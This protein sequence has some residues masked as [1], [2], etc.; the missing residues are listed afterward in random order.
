M[1]GLSGIITKNKTYSFNAR[2]KLL[3]MTEL[4][5]HRG[6]DQAGYLNFENVFLSH[7][8]LSVMDP[9]NLGR[10]PMSN[11][12]R[13]AII[14]NGEIY[15]F[16]EIRKTLTD[17][18]YTFY[19]NTDTEVGLNA[20][21]EWGDKCFNIFNGDWVISILDKVKKKIIIA[22]DQI[23][24]L[25][26]Y[27]YNDANLFAFSSE[28]KGLEPIANLQYDENFIGLNS[29]TI[30]NFHGTKFKNVS[31]VKPGTYLSI[32]LE[33]KKIDTL[34]WFSPLDNLVSIYPSYKQNQSEIF[35]R[36]YNATKLRLNADIKVGTS[37]SGGLDSSIIFLIMNLIDSNEKI[38]KVDLNPTIVNYDGNLTFNEA[39]QF[40]N[41]HE[42]KYNLFNSKMPFEIN[43]LTNLLSQLE[44]TE[45][46]N[47]QFDLY[48]EQKK[49]GIHVSVDGHGA[50]EFLG[51]LSDIPQ[52]SL[53]YYNNLVDMNIINHNYKNN[54]NIDSIDKFFGKFSHKNKK[55]NFR[56]DNLIDFSNIFS[57][58]IKYEQNKVTEQEFLIDEYFDDLQDFPLDFQYIFF[59]THGGFLQHF[60]HKWNKAGMANSVEVRSP[61]LDKNVYLYLL[62]MPI[63]KKI[64]NG[65]IKSLLKDSF[66]DH[67][68]DY[69]L[70]QN[71]KQ[72]LPREKPVS[73]NILKELISQIII[74]KN[75]SNNCWDA[76]LIK[77]DFEENKNLKLIWEL[78]K[79]YLL[80]EGFSLRMN[81]LTQKSNYLTTVTSLD[82]I[83]N[84]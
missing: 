60:T 26:L 79:H 24:S 35:Q 72:G 64:N 50:D 28:I 12:D 84:I 41:L 76:K 53:K 67:L 69:I 36:L 25:P 46:Y 22:K 4:I 61:F 29:L 31:Q 14:F 73:D 30:S 21:K 74:E 20:Y 16:L 2:D 45:E 83:E 9:R 38:T 51:M 63:E 15:N 19:T 80:K 78:C 17:K 77:K 57:K 68:P 18:G 47:K 34:R 66:S 23:G 11:D 44:L 42:R 55:A 37:L 8:R 7:V 59:K 10:Q 70:N 39:I 1:C 40:S 82:Q 62:S 3:K 75:F 48:K 13:F 43:H 58:Y 32:D 71:F 65:K 33:T 27:F 52:L 5:S 54:K 49:L 56:I 6:P 81:N